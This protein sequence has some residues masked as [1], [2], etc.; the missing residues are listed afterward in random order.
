MI[1]KKKSFN[2][3]WLTGV[4]DSYS[5][6]KIVIGI[7]I[8]LVFIM[9]SWFLVFA[10]GYLH[11]VNFHIKILKPLVLEKKATLVNYYKSFFADPEHI[12]I[13]IK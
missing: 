3:N 8:I 9:Y 11:R 1:F 5:K 10:G 13:H 12:D 6:K 7:A 2:F 4:F